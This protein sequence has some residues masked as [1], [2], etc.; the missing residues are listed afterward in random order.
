MFLLV[1][2]YPAQSESVNTTR[3]SDCSWNLC[4]MAT[5]GWD[6][7]DFSGRRAPS[8]VYFYRITTPER[9]FVKKIQVI[10]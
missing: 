7:Q 1:S 8:G 4:L 2:K 9:T 3:F 6:G 5:L 10:R